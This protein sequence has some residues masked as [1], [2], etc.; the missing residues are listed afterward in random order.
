M[1]PRPQCQSWLEEHQEFYSQYEMYV[2]HSTTQK[3]YDRP[4]YWVRLA[5][6]LGLAKYSGE[7]ICLCYIIIKTICWIDYA[8]IGMANEGL[9][10][11]WL[12]VDLIG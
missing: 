3:A 6:K 5:L 11:D 2:K 10:C 8:I 9:C 12:L 7:E 4:V 1:V